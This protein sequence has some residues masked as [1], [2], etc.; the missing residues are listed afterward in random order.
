MSAP[1]NSTADYN[2]EKAVADSGFQL[3][4]AASIALAVVTFH[5]RKGSLEIPTL[6]ERTPLG[7]EYVQGYR[8]GESSGV[9]ATFTW[10]TDWNWKGYFTWGTTE[11]TFRL[12]H[13]DRVLASSAVPLRITFD[14]VRCSGLGGTRWTIENLVVRRGDGDIRLPWLT[15]VK[16][17]IEVFSHPSEEPGTRYVELRFR[18]M[19]YGRL[20][21]SERSASLFIHAD[22]RATHGDDAF[23]AAV[24]ADYD[25][26]VGALAHG[27]APVDYENP[28]PHVLVPDSE[29]SG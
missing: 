20:T 24:G 6:R 1:F 10:R 2:A 12:G 18:W 13:G 16:A 25:R 7:A 17:E 8:K 5:L 29:E 28:I 23:R 19:E 22:G 4:T 27:A 14:R 15:E 26:V 21:N 9:D 11:S 3:V